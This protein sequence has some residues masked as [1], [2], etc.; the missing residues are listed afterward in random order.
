MSQTCDA[1]AGVFA[2]SSGLCGCPVDVQTITVGCV[3]EHVH[4]VHVC[5]CHQ[6]I[7][8]TGQSGCH[9]CKTGAQP[10]D[11]QLVAMP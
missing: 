4:E 8:R 10:H 9:T 1:P 3:H 6:A 2:A 11:C 5:P 7:L